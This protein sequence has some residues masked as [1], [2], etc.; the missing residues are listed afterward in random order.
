MGNADRIEADCNAVRPP[1]KSNTAATTP[2]VTPQK[3]F[4][5][6]GGFCTP[7]AVIIAQTKVEES[8]E[9]IKKMQISNTAM[10]EVKLAK[11]NSPKRAK[12]A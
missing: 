5:E 2:S 8:A 4:R 6:F 11:G 3:I 9:V 12:S 1:T 10:Q 7:L